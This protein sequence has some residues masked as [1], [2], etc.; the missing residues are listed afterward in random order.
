[1]GLLE[2]ATLDAGAGAVRCIDHATGSVYVGGAPLAPG[3]SGC[4]AANGARVRLDDPVGRYGLA[5]SP[6]P[7]F[8]AD[9]SNPTVRTSTGFPICIPRVAPPADDP[10][11]P[12]GNRPRNGDP[13][14]ARDALLP[15][16]AFLTRFDLPPPVDGVLP[17]AR[18]Q[19]PLEIGDWVAYSGALRRDG[20][21]T[22]ISA[23]TLVANLGVFTAPGVPP[24]YLAVDEVAIGTRG[25]EDP[26]IPQEG[27]TEFAVLGATTDPT[28]LVDIAA[29]DVNPCTGE[30]TLRVL[31][32]VDP[33]SQPVRGRFHF[34]VAGGAFMPPTRELVVLSRTG[35]APGMANG[36]TAGQYRLP[37]IDYLFPGNRVFGQPL[38]AANLEDLPFLAQGSGPQGGTGP[39]LSQLEPWPGRVAPARV[40]CSTG[41]GSPPL[42]DAGPALSATSGAPVT[43]AGS[44][45][46][47]PEGGPVAVEWTQ[48]EG[49]AV[50]LSSPSSLV[51]SFTAPSVPAVGPSATLRFTLRVTNGFGTGT[52]E[53]A[54]SVN[55]PSDAVTVTA[56]LFRSTDRMLIVTARS[57][58]ASPAVSLEVVGFGPMADMGGGSYRLAAVGVANPGTVMVRSSLGGSATRA[59]TVR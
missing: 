28:R 4:S 16:G 6:D 38:V 10:L 58:V 29:L 2:I 59:V 17:D 13:R 18:K 9:T 20:A 43:L 41:G 42:A 30:E 55:P 15:D 46:A 45:T 1:V 35:V 51:T 24:A 23:H 33:G 26:A 14:F 57:S 39:R 50:A 48:T 3:T 40:S 27:T 5:H 44:A 22:W 7:R 36:L 19:L 49:P 54:V 52:A 32:N 12:Q 31:A 21:G 37:V 8:T 11:C 56:A 34:G 53:T 47:E 25:T